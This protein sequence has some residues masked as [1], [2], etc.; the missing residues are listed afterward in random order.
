MKRQRTNAIRST[1]AATGVRALIP[2]DTRRIR[3][4][5]LQDYRKTER[6]LSKVQDQLKRYHER[7]LPGFS[8]WC[9]HTFGEQFAQLRRLQAD[10]RDKQAL[11]REIGDLASRLGL[12]DVDAYREF[13]WRRD[14]PEAAAEEDRRRQEEARQEEER[15]QKKKKN[16]KTPEPDLFDF[17]D[18]LSDEDDDDD[19]DDA[20]EDLFAS[21]LGLK[22][23]RPVKTP[24]ADLK[25][26]R[27]LYRAIVRKL[28]PD[29]HGHMSEARKHLWDEAQTAWHALDVDTL[30]NVYAQCENDEVGVGDN[31]AVSTLLQLTHRL[32][33][34]LR[35]ARAQM[36]QMSK[37]LEWDYESRMTN[38]I[39]T[40]KVKQ[41]ILDDIR[42]LRFQFDRITRVLLALEQQAARKPRRRPNPRMRTPF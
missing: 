33:G 29:H 34:A 26:A 8:A 1:P 16:K 28:H 25:T 36:R 14:N 13:L 39:Y 12:S 6:A 35:Q 10:L 21:F 11:A 20:W 27:E 15:A 42:L 24:E 7:D 3:K 23:P 30:K 17:D 41:V 32:K 19:D 18:E 4:Q 9:Q 38:V 40:R 37:K 2:L 31:T 22:R 5:A